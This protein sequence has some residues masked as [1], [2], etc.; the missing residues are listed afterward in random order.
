M[1]MVTAVI[2]CVCFWVLFNLLFVRLFECCVSCVFEWVELGFSNL[3]I[4]LLLIVSGLQALVILTSGFLQLSS[5][6]FLFNSSC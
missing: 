6:L 4:F 5:Q 2:I 1:I 3:L